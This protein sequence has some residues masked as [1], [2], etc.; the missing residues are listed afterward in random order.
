MESERGLVKAQQGRGRLG[1]LHAI[2]RFALD[3][4]FPPVCIACAQAVST[5][6]GL[7]TLCWTQ[8]QP[9]TDPM[10][11]VLGL[12][13]ATDMG[14]GA[15]SPQA[16]ANPPVFDRARSAVAYTDLARKL[17]SRMKYSDRPEIALFCA[18]MI[19]NAAPDILAPD[20]VL[21]P[22][23]LHPFRR[24]ARRYNQ[25]AELARILAR[26]AKLPL[27]TN[28]VA[29]H[30]RTS[31]QVGLNAR[32]RAANVTGAFR[33]DAA[34]LA[35]YGNKRIIV[36][37]DVVTT[38]ATATAIAKTLKRAGAGHVDVLSFARVVF[39]EDMTV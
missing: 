19:L 15:A 30:R 1:S 25:S 33:A 26:L 21:V 23:P 12:P 20:G 2:G 28:L 34:R 32:Q 3:Q 27:D 8:L 17:V 13:F 37:D 36:V 16:I 5:P 10:C 31:Q 6:D 4:L 22:V 38:G 24:M 11:P 7:C 29:R 9:I 35:R 14:A 39:D 18:R